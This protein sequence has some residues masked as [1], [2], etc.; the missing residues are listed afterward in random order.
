MIL[1]C[2]E[3]YLTSQVLLIGGDYFHVIRD[4]NILVY[5]GGILEYLVRCQFMT[6]ISIEY[7][8]FRGWLVFYHGG[9]LIL[10]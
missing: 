8:W 9:L 2:S 1:V 3:C 5:Y 6:P 10:D 4:F 7:L